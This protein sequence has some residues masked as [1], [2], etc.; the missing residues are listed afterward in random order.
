MNQHACSLCVGIA[1]LG[2][3][4]HRS[5]VC[6]Y[7]Y[8]RLYKGEWS[9]NHLQGV[10]GGRKGAV[11]WTRRKGRSYEIHPFMSVLCSV[12]NVL[13]VR[14]RRLLK[15]DLLVLQKCCWSYKFFFNIE[16]KKIAWNSQTTLILIHFIFIYFKSIWDI[17][18]GKLVNKNVPKCSLA[19]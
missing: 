5:N 12:L 19:L 1:R 2:K 8:N 11:K 4:P 17:L 6:L 15:M 14:P 7:M 9:L 10:V 16:R 13:V 3:G 18:E